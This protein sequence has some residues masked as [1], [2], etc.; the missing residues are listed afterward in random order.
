MNYNN[1]HP[2][3]KVFGNLQNGERGCG[4]DWGDFLNFSREKGIAI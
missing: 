4:A 2:T 3:P 1:R